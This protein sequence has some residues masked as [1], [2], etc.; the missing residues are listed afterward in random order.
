MS[1]STA[2]VHGRRPDARSLSVSLH[3]VAPATWPAC[4]RV[5]DAIAQVERL[6]QARVPVALLVVPRYRGVD[7]ALDRGFLRAIEARA[8]AGDELVLHGYTH[9]DEH[10]PV[11]WAAPFDVLRRRVY[12]A[13]EGEFSALARDEASRR[14]EAGLAWFAARGWPVRGFVAPAWLMSQGTH[15]A[16][17]DTP[18]AYAG[19]RTEL[20]LLRSGERV[21]APSLVY[22]TR[23]AWRR[24]MSLRFNPALARLSAPRPLLR[25]ALH[26]ADGQY[27]DVRASWEGLLQAA[28]LTRRACTEG[29][30][31]DQLSAR[32][33]RG[34]PELAL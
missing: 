1:A 10:A 13:S 7:S 9:V 29:D 25:L 26:P 27:G 33:E 4:E 22:S 12:T 31:V 15:A 17:H 14:I 2:V 18:L 24:A 23:N 3:D 19:T 11:G 34:E 8:S 6:T 32:S 16:L 5:L 30:L 21:G 28:L 20:L